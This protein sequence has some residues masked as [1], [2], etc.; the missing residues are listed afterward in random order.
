VHTGDAQRSGKK[1]SAGS[2]DAVKPKQ[3]IDKRPD[4]LSGV[5]GVGKRSI[6][7]GDCENRETF[8]GI[9]RADR[10]LKRIR[11]VIIAIP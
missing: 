7:I 2:L 1:Q 11:P 8:K 9:A 6:C 10:V 4:H 5:I 3:V